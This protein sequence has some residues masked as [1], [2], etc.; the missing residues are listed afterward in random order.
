MPL[1]WNPRQ[2]EASRMHPHPQ[3][4]NMRE[5]EER[6][7]CYFMVT[8]RYLVFEKS[9]GGGLGSGNYRQN[10]LGQG[11]TLPVPRRSRCEE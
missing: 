1:M 11:P 6:A 7:N 10:A 3:L 4:T 8:D 2:H 9:G 5:L